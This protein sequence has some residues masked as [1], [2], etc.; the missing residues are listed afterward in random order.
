MAGM[1]RRQLL[2][3]SLGAATAG[4]ALAGGATVLP[5]LLGITA[6]AA[7]VSPSAES[8]RTDLVVH[9]RPGTSGELRVMSG[10]H[11]VVVTDAKLVSR[12]RSA[13]TH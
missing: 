4:A 5:K 7:T 12:L 1:T 10:D 13:S 9:V 11:E 3:K 6:E 8:T 2:G